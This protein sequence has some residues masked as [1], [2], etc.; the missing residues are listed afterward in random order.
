MWTEPTETDDESQIET[1]I[2]ESM[3]LPGDTEHENATRYPGYD[4]EEGSKIIDSITTTSTE[5]HV[6]GDAITAYP[7][8]G[9]VTD[10]QPDDGDSS[11]ITEAP[12]D[13]IGP[14][15]SSEDSS[16]DLQD[17]HES[18][19]PRREETLDEPG[20]IEGDASKKP[21]HNLD[22]DDDAADLNFRPPS[23]TPGVSLN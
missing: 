17:E 11:Q 7:D 23:V 1:P 2:D 20:E 8:E 15:P 19:R 12:S 10:S 16:N 5:S 18:S 3:R 21:P 13:H 9:L 14:P 6:D 22:V 4:D